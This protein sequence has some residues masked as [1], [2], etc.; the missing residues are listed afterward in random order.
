M[1]AVGIFTVVLGGLGAVALWSQA[2]PATKT[3]GPG[4]QAAADSKEPDVLKTC[5]TP[6]PARGGGRA[7]GGGGAAKALQAGRGSPGRG[8]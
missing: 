6:P 2:P 3:T 8:S 4:V 1:R 7:G 5:K